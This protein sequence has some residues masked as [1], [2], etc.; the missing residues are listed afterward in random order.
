ME[1]EGYGTIE[2]LA[3][4][5]GKWVSR[6]LENVL[7]VPK[8]KKNLF[9]IGAATSK[10]LKV[11]FDEEKLEIYGN[12]LLA[13]GIKQTNKCYKMLFKMPNA[14]ANISTSDFTMLW[15]ERLGHVNF[16]T[17]K[18]MADDGL[19]S[20]TTININN[21]VFCE[22]CQHEKLSR[23]P[24]KKNI[25]ER[26]SRPG[27]AVHMDIC[28]KMSHPSIGGAHYFLLFKDECTSYRIAYFIKHKSD[29]F[30]RFIQFQNLSEKQT[31]NKLKRVRS[32]RG[33]E[34]NNEQFK[35]HIQKEGIIH[36]FSAPY[37]PEQN[38]SIERE[39]RSIVEAARTMLYAAKLQPGLWAE[40][41]NTSVY[42]LNRRPRELDKQIPFELWTGKK[43]TLNHLKRFGSEVYTHIPKQFRSKFE[44]KAKK[45]ILVGYDGNSKNYRVMDPETLKI[46]VTR[47]VV[48][49]EKDNA[50]DYTRK[51]E[52]ATFSFQ[53]SSVTSDGRCDSFLSLKLY[54]NYTITMCAGN[55]RRYPNQGNEK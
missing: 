13:T 15:H 45:M 53:D 29:A 21:E 9:S 47:D 27:E 26:A 3:L 24:F 39:N 17:L 18:K 16:K 36:E 37:S 19:L 40:A 44:S 31:G 30:S 34:F 41:V 23:L 1:I 4:V 43:L 22:A 54:K 49:N 55:S 11:I 32:D 8:L 50:Q 5:H 48:V 51:A 6:T 20:N 25:Q 46:T 42:L 35:K 14:Q 12:R 38:G 7:Y 33:L 10:S 28:G 2:I 52:L